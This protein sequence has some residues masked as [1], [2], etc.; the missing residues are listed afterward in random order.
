M[1]VSSVIKEHLDDEQFRILN[2]IATIALDFGTGC[3]LVGGA[4]R[5]V[6]KGRSS[7]DLDIMVEHRFSEIADAVAE[8]L[9]GTVLK[10]T[11]FGTAAL[12]I[13]AIHLDISTARCETYEESGALP[14]V[15]PGTLEQDLA[16][17]DFTINA[18][19]ISLSRD[20][21]GDLIDHHDGMSDLENGVVRVLHNQ[22]FQDDATRILR[23]IRFA[24]RE[25]YQL[26]EYT[27]RLIR[28][29]VRYLET[30]SGERIRHEIERIFLEPTSSAMLQVANDL[31]ILQAIHPA[32]AFEY[33][34]VEPITCDFDDLNLIFYGLITRQ[35]SPEDVEP[36]ITRLMLD[37][38]RAAFVNDI[39]SIRAIVPSLRLS[40][41]NS[42]TY[43]LLEGLQPLA[44]GAYATFTDDAEAVKRIRLYLD[45]LRCVRPSIT[46]ESLLAEGVPEGPWIGQL[47]KSLLAARLDGDISSYEEEVEFVR[48]TL[49][50][51]S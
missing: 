21:F 2:G 30:V 3:Y 14:K 20:S 25:G 29:D 18:M 1:N 49:W 26:D 13:G 31:K 22:S 19:A 42:E 44:L 46:G 32:L 45:E 15:F 40:K 4:V 50:G 24:G 33:S 43:Y 38:V 9:G 7:G 27:E 11:R 28:R 8:Q 12:D 10:V 34:I 47:L 16:R 36:I 51:G 41:F 5:D 48:R 35:A 37:S 23:A 17:R 6:L 39:V